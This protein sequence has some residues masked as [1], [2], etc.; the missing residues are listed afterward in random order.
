[1]LTAIKYRSIT[2]K[3]M[4]LNSMNNILENPPVTAL[5]SKTSQNRDTLCLPLKCC[6]LQD[7][8]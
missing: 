4:Y 8:M 6:C 2:K 1:M 3:K 5:L 7:E